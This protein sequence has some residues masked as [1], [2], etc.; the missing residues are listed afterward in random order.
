MS[1]HP[2]AGVGDSFFEMV[3][4]LPNLR[5]GVLLTA[6]A[7]SL[8]FDFT[9]RQKI[10]GTNL[11]FFYVR[12]LPLPVPGS[13]EAHR[14]F[15]APRVLELCY[16]AWDMAPFGSELDYHGPPFRWETERRDLIRA[17]IDA[18]MFRL[19][20]IGSDDI[21]YILDHMFEGVGK[22]DMRRWGE[23]RTKRLVLER[24][25]AMAEAKRRG[26][27]YQTILDPAPAHY[28]IAQNG[29]P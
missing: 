11:S 6:I 21:A 15:I 23:Y 28:S 27:P 7:N 24:Y 2:R 4:P 12:Q 9:T 14:S 3:L 16:T 13:I 8:V 5:N 18:L 1:P 19:Y 22:Y 10:G 20:G 26:Q 29:R 25:D 17:E